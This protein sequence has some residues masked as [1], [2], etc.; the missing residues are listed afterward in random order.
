MQCQTYGLAMWM[1]LT[2]GAIDSQDDYSFRSA[3][4]SGMSIITLPNESGEPEGCETPEQAFSVD[5]LRKNVGELAQVQEYFSGDFFPLLSYSLAS[6]AWAVSQFDRPDLGEGT[7]L[8]IR[9]QDSPFTTMV[10][11]LH[12]LVADV[13]YEVRCLDDG[14]IVQATGADLA[15][16]GLT[17]EIPEKRSSRLFLYKRVNA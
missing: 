4:S 9:R 12:G 14:T 17:I 7:V 8:A 16:C 1:P 6:D 5:W 3:L 11:P 2:V 15:D 13:E 10:T